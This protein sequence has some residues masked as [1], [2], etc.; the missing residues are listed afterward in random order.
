MNLKS[1]RIEIR[2]FIDVCDFFS[3]TWSNVFDMIAIIRFRNVICNKNV[4][5][6]NTIHVKFWLLP[7]KLTVLKSPNPSLKEYTIALMK[8]SVSSD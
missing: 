4:A 2:S 6:T 5:K 3:I 8:E 7:L 1:A